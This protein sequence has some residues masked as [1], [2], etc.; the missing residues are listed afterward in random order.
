VPDPLQLLLDVQDRDLSADQLRHRRASLPERLARAEQEGLIVRVDTELAER[1]ARLADL[2]RSQKRIEDDVATVQAKSEGENK[3]L[4]SG[5]VT[6]PREL[7]AM[8]EEI[9]ALT[10]RQHDLEDEVIVLMETAEPL[11]EEIDRLEALRGAAETDAARLAALI[12]EAEGV[13]DG[14][15]AAVLADRDGIAAGVPDDLLATYE[16]LRVHLD[17]IGVARLD[18]VQCTGCHLSLPATE[19]AAVRKATPGA[20]VYHEECGR[21]LVP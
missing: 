12:V 18:G 11:T 9:D 20:V 15:L 6:S 5:T 14:E 13:I 19:V 10:R 17:G 7:Q 1:Q 21:I 3:K 2:Q 8:Q 16:K 4:Y